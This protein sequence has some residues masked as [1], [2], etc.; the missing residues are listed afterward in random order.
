MGD[1]HRRPLSSVVLLITDPS[2][3]PLQSVLQGGL[4]TCQNC[5]K[6]LLGKQAP[7]WLAW[8]FSLLFLTLPETPR[9][10]QLLCCAH[11]LMVKQRGTMASTPARTAVLVLYPPR[12]SFLS[13]RHLSLGCSTDVFG[14][15]AEHWLRR[16][17]WA[18][19]MAELTQ[20]RRR[21]SQTVHAPHPLPLVK[22]T[23]WI[24]S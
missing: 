24:L 20:Y 19:L 2:L 16:C 4:T 5:Q 18:L 1:M 11:S 17:V 3:T 8:D 9:E 10:I 15:Q 22:P 7:L 14:S 13:T 21:I 23:F 6:S 12:T